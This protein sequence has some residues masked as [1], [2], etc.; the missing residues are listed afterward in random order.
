MLEASGLN[1]D[2][3]TAEDA[4]AAAQAAAEADDM[5]ATPNSNGNAGATVV[6]A[7]PSA[8]G[9]LGARP[10]QSLLRPGQSL[11]IMTNNGEP[12]RKRLKP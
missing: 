11:L 7:G 6:Q 4:A 8:S 10:G 12:Q 1:F 9:S 5:A 3:G 2:V